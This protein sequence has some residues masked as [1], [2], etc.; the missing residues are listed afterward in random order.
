MTRQTSV[1]VDL[2]PGTSTLTFT[3]SDQP[4][5]V[6]FDYVDILLN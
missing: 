4:G 1:V 3:K 5:T 6:D 2:Q